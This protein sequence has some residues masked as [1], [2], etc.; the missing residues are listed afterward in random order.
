MSNREERFAFWMSITQ[1]LVERE[2]RSASMTVLLGIQE[3][4]KTA[5]VQHWLESLKEQDASRPHVW[6]TIAHPHEKPKQFCQRLLHELEREASSS[7]AHLLWDELGAALRSNVDMSVIDQA[8]QM[9]L[10]T[11]QYLRSYVFDKW[12]VSIF[13]AGRPGLEKTLRSDPYIESRIGAWH[14]IDQFDIE[15]RPG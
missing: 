13:F 12:A 3:S 1:P 10:L 14:T 9:A 11:A 5:L 8:E 4:G 7:D 2:V 15:G 6:Y